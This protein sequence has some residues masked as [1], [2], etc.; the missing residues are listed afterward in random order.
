MTTQ[1]A[2]ITILSTP[3]FKAWLTK[4]ARTEGVSLSELVR[5]RCQAKPDPDEAVLSDLIT[6]VRLATEK[7]K[8][9]LTQGLQ[10]AEA[11]LDELRSA[12]K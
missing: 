5:R 6:E 4:E 2:R 8:A 9:S 12:R 11:T 3:D 10:D 1:T 7:A